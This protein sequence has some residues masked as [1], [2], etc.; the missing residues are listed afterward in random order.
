[1]RLRVIIGDASAVIASGGAHV[2]A[3]LA[4][5]ARDAARHG[6][7]VTR[8]GDRVTVTGAGGDVVAR[9]VVQR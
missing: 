9:Y 4:D 5:I 8:N 6:H 1:M 2:G 7:T 3:V